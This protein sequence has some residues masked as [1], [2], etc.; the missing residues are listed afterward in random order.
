MDRIERFQ[1]QEYYRE[2]GRLVYNDTVKKNV[3][4]MM[5][6]SDAR[7]KIQKEGMN[8]DVWDIV[9]TLS[10]EIIY[11]ILADQVFKNTIQRIVDKRR[12]TP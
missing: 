7:I 6:T 10:N 8:M 4:I 5:D 3:E 11:P 1:D 2:T 9:E 12:G